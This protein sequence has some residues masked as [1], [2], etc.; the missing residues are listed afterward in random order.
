LPDQPSIDELK[1]KLNRALRAKAVLVERSKQLEQQI[2]DW[3]TREDRSDHVVS[4]LLDRQ[5]ELNFMLHRANSVLQRIQDANAALSSEFTELVKELPAP[6]TPDWEQRVA[7]INELFRKTGHMADEMADEIF[8][9]GLDLHEPAPGSGTAAGDDAAATSDSEAGPVSE[10]RDSRTAPEAEPTQEL[11]REPQAAAPEPAPLPET[12]TVGAAC[13]SETTAEPKDNAQEADRNGT[14]VD[15]ELRKRLDRLFSRKKDGEDDPAALSGDRAPAAASRRPGILSRIW[16]RITGRGGKNAS[17]V[18]EPEENPTD[19]P[20]V[21]PPAAPVEDTA[22]SK[23]GRES[24]MEARAEPA[25]YEVAGVLEDAAEAIEHISIEV[26]PAA[27]EE[28]TAAIEAVEP[29][30]QPSDQAALPAG[31]KA[32]SFWSRLKARSA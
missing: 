17:E 25:A 28:E 11:G 24:L 21:K 2:R 13:E 27:G 6:Q 23:T 19:V 10:D 16:R 1:Q 4:E 12:E 18:E 22:S 9:R 5:R 26:I 3:R 7:K 20:E 15:P 8:R 14:E 32:R 30:L 29:A 31:I